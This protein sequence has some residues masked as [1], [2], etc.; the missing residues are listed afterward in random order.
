MVVVI[1]DGLIHQ[2]LETGLE[3]AVDVPVTQ[4]AR[5]LVTADVQTLTS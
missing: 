5:T 2:I 3:I 1:E 4:D